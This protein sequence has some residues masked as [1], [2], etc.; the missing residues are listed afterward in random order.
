[1]RLISVYYYEK[2]ERLDTLYRMLEERTPEESISHREMP[3][4]EE[5]EAFVERRPYAVWYFI[6]PDNNTNE[7]LGNLYLTENREI[8]IHVR[9]GHRGQ[10]VGTEALKEMQRIHRGPFLANVNP[11]NQK[12]IDLFEKFGFQHIQNTY[13]LDA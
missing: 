3:T 10:G 8:G 6:T 11:N 4:R 12:S 2:K 5:H 13:R 9:V 1:M 7:I